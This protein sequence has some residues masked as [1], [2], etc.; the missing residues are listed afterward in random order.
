[1]T[2]IQ[3]A[4]ALIGAA[5]VVGFALGY[6]I[7]A[8]ISARPRRHFRNDLPL[9]TSPLLV[10]ESGG[11]VAPDYAKQIRKEPEAEELERTSSRHRF[12][13]LEF[14]TFGPGRAREGL[15]PPPFYVVS[16]TLNE[17][18]SEYEYRVKS[19]LNGKECILTESDLILYK[20]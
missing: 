13:T 3:I 17:P 20:S 2:P 14:V 10:P 9:H 8:H 4:M 12:R 18:S 11:D 7:R 16:T 6:G 5:L 1:M 15:P 19:C